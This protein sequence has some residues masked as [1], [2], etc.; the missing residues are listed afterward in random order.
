MRAQAEQPGAQDSTW[1]NRGFSLIELLIVVAVILTIAGIAIPNFI[2]SK[3]RAN[4]T[5]AVQNL[6]HVF[7]AN[8]IYSTIY[9]MGFAVSLAALG[10]TPGNPAQL[11]SS[12]AG[13]IDDVLAAGVKTGYAFT[14]QATDVNGD[15]TMDIYTVQA[16][17]LN[18]GVTGTRHYFTDQT[19][20]IRYNDTAPATATDPPIS[21]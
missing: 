11:S 5:G 16:D 8:V 3:M 12:H 21:P 4:E 19:G 6:R 17:P 18:P 9:N 20:V 1:T 7:S 14:Y 2:R 15:G 13:L 10:P